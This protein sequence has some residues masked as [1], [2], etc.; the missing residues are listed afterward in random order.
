MLCNC[1]FMCLCAVIVVDCVVWYGVLFVLFCV[2]VVCVVCLC[3]PF[4]VQRAV[5]HRLVQCL[6]CVC[7]F[8]CTVEHGCA[9][10]L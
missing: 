1:M 5:L 10:R 8:G 4:V 2:L 3:D 9:S 6:A 7:V